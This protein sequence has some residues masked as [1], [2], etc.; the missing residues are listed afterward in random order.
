[1]VEGPG[2]RSSAS[3][4]ELLD[5]EFQTVATFRPRRAG[6]GFFCDGTTPSRFIQTIFCLPLLFRICTIHDSD[7]AH[8]PLHRRRE[9]LR[10]AKALGFDIDYKRLLEGV[11]ERGDL[12]RAYYYTAMIEDQEYSPIR[13]LVDWLDYNGFPS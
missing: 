6:P 13:P 4:A 1:M 7:P 12:M 2:R 9:P 5:P 3:T 10:P 8:R 11:P